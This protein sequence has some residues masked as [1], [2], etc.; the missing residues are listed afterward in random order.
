MYYLSPI[1]VQVGGLDKINKAVPLETNPELLILIC[2]TARVA[3][4]IRES[5][6]V[7]NRR[8][9]SVYWFTKKVNPCEYFG[10]YRQ[11]RR[12]LALSS[13]GGVETSSHHPTAFKSP[14]KPQLVKSSSW[15]D[16]QMAVMAKTRS[17]AK[18]TPRGIKGIGIQALKST[19]LYKGDREEF[20][21]QIAATKI[22]RAW[23]ARGPA[24]N[25][26]NDFSEHDVA[27]VGQ[28]RANASSK[29]TNKQ[30][31]NLSSSLSGQAA[32]VAGSNLAKSVKHTI[33]KASTYTATRRRPESQVGSAMRELTGQRVAI[34]IIIALVLTMFFTYAEM[35]LTVPA[36]MILLHN[37]T[38]N[39]QYADAALE[40]ARATSIPNLFQYTLAN[41]EVKDFTLAGGT[42]PSELR[43]REIV[44]ISVAGVVNSTTSVTGNSTVGLFDVKDEVHNNAWV[45]ILTT[46]FILLVWFFGVNAFAGPVM[47]LVVIPI[48]R[49]I[50]LLG[51]LM[52]DPLG[53]QST[54]RYKKFVAEEDEL[55]KNTMWTKEVLKGMET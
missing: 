21:Q 24:A 2:R 9:S 51:M 43:P 12:S 22:Q 14:T 42:K 49:M 25:P 47:M 26:N 4:C 34:G 55:T 11:R 38:A 10:E 32:A 33:N 27:W 53:Y 39:E 7:K 29:P 23:R 41:G 5:T 19:G 3:R 36:A 18:E 30:L 35:D 54:S 6:V 45:Q 52:M 17:Y 20:R 37:Q 50:R 31:K 1:C 28:R 13:E 44:R 16:L 8:L 40:A 46:L 15:S 48:E